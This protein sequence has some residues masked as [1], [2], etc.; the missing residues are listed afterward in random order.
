ME[1]IGPWKKLND[2]VAY[3]N[4]WIRVNHQEVLNPNGN[5]GIYGKIHF[6]NLA[7]GVIPLDEEMNTWIVGQHRYPLNQYSWEIPEGGGKH[8]V[9]P[10]ESARRELLEECGLIAEDWTRVIDLHLSNSVSD[11]HAIIYVARGLK[12]VEAEPED[13]E[14]LVIR[15]L[16]FAALFEMV[17]NG[18]VTDA[19]SV[20][21]VL[22]VQ[23]LLLENRI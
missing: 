1:E 2:T 19:M 5:P 10:I 7:I 14:Q 4:P 16:P 20:S 11:E 6:K 9:D 12:Q 22:K 17:M 15:K 21:A 23:H 13:T 8:D 3:E 18:E